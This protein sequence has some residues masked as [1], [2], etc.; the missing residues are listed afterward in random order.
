M[1]FAAIALWGCGDA[2]N[3]ID[4]IGGVQSE[5]ETRQDLDIEGPYMKLVTTLEIG[6]KLDFEFMPGSL[7]TEVIGATKVEEYQMNYGTILVFYELTDPTVYIKGDVEYIY[8]EHSELTSL[9]ISNNPALKH[10]EC[11]YNKLTSLDVSENYALERLEC[12]YNQLAELE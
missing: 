5:E 12:E 6:E 11:G 1:A 4:E 3:E 7:P 9:D 8:C 2:S 10:I